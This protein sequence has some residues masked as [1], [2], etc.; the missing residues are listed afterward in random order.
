MTQTENRDLGPSEE[1]DDDKGRREE[2]EIRM[3]EIIQTVVEDLDETGKRMWRKM[4]GIDSSSHS[5]AQKESSSNSS[6]SSSSS[7]SGTSSTSGSSL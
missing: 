1:D 2:Y 6:S 7:S 4:L 5:C 3:V